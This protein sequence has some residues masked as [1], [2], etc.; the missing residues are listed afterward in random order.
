MGAIATSKILYQKREPG[1]A[2]SE[3]AD[4]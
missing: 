1:D 3:K 2:V 4:F